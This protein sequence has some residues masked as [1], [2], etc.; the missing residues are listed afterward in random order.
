MIDFTAASTVTAAVFS[1]TD[2]KLALA[3]ADNRDALVRWL[4]AR[5]HDPDLAE[6]LVHEAFIRLMRTMRAGVEIENPR[7]WL[8]HAASNLL[9]SHVRRVR[10][11]E[12]HAPDSDGFDTISAETVVLAQER[13]AHLERVLRQ[14]SPADRDVLVATGLGEDGPAYAAR[15]GVSQVA[16][17]TRLCRARKRVRDLVESDEGSCLQAA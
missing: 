2:D 14:L 7:A 3:Y 12:R 4:T 16:A 5:T 8:F 6:E 15:T 13:M 11:A 9:I 17:R 1:A 10:V